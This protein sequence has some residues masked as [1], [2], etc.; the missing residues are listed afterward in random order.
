MTSEKID[1][2]LNEQSKRKTATI[3]S[4]KSDVERY[5]GD[6]AA[7]LYSRNP[8]TTFRYWHY[9]LGEQ[10]NQNNVRKRLS[11]LNSL[12]F[13][14]SNTVR[15][16]YNVC[17]G[18]SCSNI[19]APEEL[20]SAIISES[21][22]MASIDP[23]YTI[24]AITI[25]IPVWYSI[26]KRSAILDATRLLGLTSKVSL[27]HEHHLAAVQ[28]QNAKRFTSARTVAFFDMGATSTKLF[29]VTFEPNSKIY[30]LSSE[31]DESLGGADIDSAIAKY[32]ASELKI[33]ID[34]DPKV[35]AR[36]LVQSR[37]AKEVLS[38]NHET[39]ISIED[40]H[41]S[42]DK[43]Y[44]LT[45][46]KLIILCSELSQKLESFVKKQLQGSK[47]HSLEVIGGSS[48]IPFVQE[49][50]R[51]ALGHKLELSFTLNGDETIALGAALYNS[52]LIGSRRVNPVVKDI[53][54]LKLKIISGRKEINVGSQLVGAQLSYTFDAPALDGIIIAH[55]DG[56]HILKYQPV[57][58]DSLKKQW[59][60]TSFKLVFSSDGIPSIEQIQ[61]VTSLNGKTTSTTLKRIVNYIGDVKPLDANSLR[62]GRQHVRNIEANEQI[63]KLVAHQNNVLENKIYSLKE[64]IETEPQFKEQYD[65]YNKILN[66]ALDW[67]NSISDNHTITAN[68][69]LNK[70]DEKISQLDDV[71]GLLTDGE[72]NNTA[73]QEVVGYC[74]KV[75]KSL[76]KEASQRIDRTKIA[77]N[78]LIKRSKVK[79]VPKVMID[80]IQKRCR[81]LQDLFLRNKR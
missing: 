8:E 33:D 63:R 62:E 72:D 73:F 25:A 71:F 22:R 1:I 30:I 60:R 39:I 15:K 68:E 28:Y 70:V 75:F 35:M 66:G 50:L 78:G 79:C 42:A 54:P 53:Y 76:S 5:I 61:A 36:L 67:Y 47:L 23:L 6:P 26:E 65:R 59:M 21:I 7:Q 51:S 31:A 80:D 14:N 9:L 64:S 12:P 27:V 48:R 56:R 2:V 10:S 37:K 24:K 32:I 34:T 16:S 81:N 49:L 43:R 13:I 4:Y 55:Q 40:L 69:L 20:T 41:G 46:G 77:L 17:L 44:T 38:A 52:K 29:I 11:A 18:S 45:R 74:R 3:I 19:L 57:I 58:S